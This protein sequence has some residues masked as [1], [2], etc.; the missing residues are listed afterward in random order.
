MD[1][2]KSMVDAMPQLL[3]ALRAIEGAAVDH[4]WPRS[5]MGEDTI[6]LTEIT[7]TNTGIGVVDSLAYQVDAWSDDPDRTEELSRQADGILTG[8]GFLRS[9]YTPLSIDGFGYRK[10]ARYSRRVDKRYMRLVD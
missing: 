4:R 5:P 1:E 2:V 8:I 6:I 9:S 7:N 10:S 3:T